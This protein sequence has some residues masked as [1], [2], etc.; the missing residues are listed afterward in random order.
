MNRL[1]PL[2][3]RED[4]FVT[5]NAESHIDPALIERR[6]DYV[7]P[8]YNERSIAAQHRWSEISSVDRRTHFAGAYWN[9]GF[10]EDGLVSGLRVARALGAKW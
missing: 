4:L 10:H 3:T 9:Y 1:Q 2:A 6:M 7:H 8:K 5:L